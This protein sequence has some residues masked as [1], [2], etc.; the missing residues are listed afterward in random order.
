[1]RKKPSLPILIVDDEELFLKSVSL[2]LKSAQINN[3]VTC[4][5]SRQVLELLEKD[6]YSL[7]LLDMLMPGVSGDELARVITRNYPETPLIIITAVNEV[8]TAVECMKNG[9]FDYILKPVEKSRLLGAIKRAL[10]LGDIR[11]ENR[12]L[13]QALLKNKLEQ[14]DAFSE[15]VTQSPVMKSIFQYIE[16]IAA[17]FLPVLISG[18]TGVG[19]ELVA[20]AVHR[21]SGRK[22][23]FVPINVAGLDDTL[24]SDAL[25][26]HKKGAFTGAEM[27]RKGLIEQAAE[28]TLFL[29]EIGELSIESQVKLLRF[30]QEGKYYPLGSDIAK[31]ADVRIVAATN[32]N[33]DTL[34]A[35]GKFR[36]D[37]FYRLKSHQVFIPPLRKRPDDIPLLVE[38]FLE[39]AATQLNKVKPTAP[40][41]LY[42]LLKTYHF[43]G[44]I[45]EL[46]GIV[47]DAVSQHKSGVLSMAPFRKN[48]A[49]Q[50]DES[51]VFE[52]DTVENPNNISEKISFHDQLPTLKEVEKGLIDEALKRAEGNQTIAAR[53]IGM[54]RKALNNRLLRTAKESG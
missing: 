30:L 2:T 35:N 15:I 11:R 52:T 6:S 22:G 54:S 10:E 21:L 45:R 20:N 47:Y 28:G 37:L 5:D 31:V 26:G 25:F 42:T 43:P 36:K 38:H 24:F 51:D 33:L 44:N 40:R 13:K 53:L 27:D 18:E 19:K 17:T 23:Q 29:D 34:Q 4:S 50:P 12:M 16:A 1:M 3:I 8:E 9:V 41:E 7:I 46:E 48:I 49:G 14:P 39:K 32:Q